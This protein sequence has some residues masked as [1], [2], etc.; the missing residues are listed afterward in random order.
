MF[1]CK[2]MQILGQLHD[3]LYACLKEPAQ[4]TILVVILK[5]VF[6]LFIWK[7][8]GLKKIGLIVSALEFRLRPGQAHGIVVLWTILYF[9][10]YSSLPRC[11]NEKK[12]KN[13]LSLL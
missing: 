5:P 2:L 8:F 12:K 6:H 9:H 1:T 10:W 7:A 4:A 3:I 11:I 13:I